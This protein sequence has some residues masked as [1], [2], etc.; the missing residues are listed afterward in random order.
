MDLLQLR[1]FLAL[2]ET[3]ALTKTAKKLYISPSSLSATISKLEKE[4]DVRLFDRPGRMI[5]LNNNGKTFYKHVKTAIDELD[6]AI[7]AINKDTSVTV[8]VDSPNMWSAAISDFIANHPHIQINNKIM[9]RNK[10]HPDMLLND[11]DFWLSSCN[12]TNVMENINIQNLSS[13]SLY[14]AVPENSPLSSCSSVSLSSLKDVNF[15]FPYFGYKYYDIYWEACISAGFYPKI[16][17]NC[18]FLVR[19]KMVSNGQGVTFVDEE[20][21]NSDLFKNIAFISISDAPPLDPAAIC[22]HKDRKLS[23]AAKTFMQFIILYF[24][25]R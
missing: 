6:Y 5:I 14:L 1:Y 10:I 4:L 17:T 23:S 18:S 25:D 7:T 20:T 22:W 13:S 3:G 2:A 15:L 9:K 12:F 24:Q 8:I 21:K 16:I 19:M 11:Y